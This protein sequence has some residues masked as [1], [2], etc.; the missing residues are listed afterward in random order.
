MHS[1]PYCEIANVSYSRRKLSGLQ[2]KPCPQNDS[3]HVLSDKSLVIRQALILLGE[4]TSIPPWNTLCKVYWT[5]THL[6]SYT[7]NLMSRSCTVLGVGRGGGR[8]C[9][10]GR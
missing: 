2:V 8:G 9:K 3:Q 5:A 4:L 1:T 6:L 7:S 10:P